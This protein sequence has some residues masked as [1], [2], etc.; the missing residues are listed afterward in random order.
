MRVVFTRAEE[1]LEELEREHELVERKIVRMCHLIERKRDL[2]IF[3][4]SIA[5][6]IVVLGQLIELKEFVGEVFEASEMPTRAPVIL[7]KLKTKA[8]ALGLDIRAGRFEP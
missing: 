4:L 8:E 5:A 6:G 2:P 1:F 7:E 3:T